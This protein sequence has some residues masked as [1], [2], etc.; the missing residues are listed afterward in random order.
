MKSIG[1]N[2]RVRLTASLIAAAF[3]VAACSNP[4][5]TEMQDRIARD[6]ETALAGPAPQLIAWSPDADATGVPTS[7]TITATFDVE[8]DEST[9][10]A[11]N[12]S[13]L[14]LPGE[15][16]VPGTLSYD[17]ASRTVS[18]TPSSRLDVETTYQLIVGTGVT[19]APGAQLAAELTAS[20]TTRFFHDDE[21]G[22][23]LTYTSSDLQ[24]DSSFPIYAEV[25]ALPW[26]Q[27][28]MEPTIT[29]ITSVQMIASG[30]Y[31]L[32]P[33]DLPAASE[34]L[35]LLFHDLNDDGTNDSGDTERLISLGADG[36]MED[37][38][39][40]DILER[41]SD[42]GDPLVDAD[43]NYII[44]EE[45]VVTPGAGY[46]LVYVDGSPVS[47]DAF[48]TADASGPAASRELSHGTTEIARNLHNL[49]DV[50][51]LRFTPATTDFYEITVGAT[52]FDLRVR[53]FNSDSEATIPTGAVASSTGQD[54]RVI[55]PGGTRLEG[56]SEYYLRVESPTSGLGEYEIAY[57]FAPI[58]PDGFEDTDDTKGGAIPLALGVGSPVSRTLEPYDH[59]W[60][61]IT[62]EEG[63]TYILSVEE[64]PSVLGW[65]L[66]ERGLDPGFRLEIAGSTSSTGIYD[67]LD[68][69]TLHIREWDGWTGADGTFYV[70]VSNNTPMIGDDKPGAAYTISLSYGPDGADTPD[71][72]NTDLT[73]E[74]AQFNEHA[75]DYQSS[76]YIPLGT[77]GR[78]RTIYTVEPGLSPEEDVDWLSF[79]VNDVYDDYLV[80]I[81][82]EGAQDAVITDFVLYPSKLDANDNIVPDTNTTTASSQWWA[83]DET[84]RAVEFYPL[85]RFGHPVPDPLSIMDRTWW[86]R[87]E[88]DSW[89]QANPLTGRYRV[90]VQAAP[91][92]L[93]NYY[94]DSSQPDGQV[95][96]RDANGDIFYTGGRDETPYLGVM[97]QQNPGTTLEADNRLDWSGS[98]GAYSIPMTYNSIFRKNYGNGR[99]E[100]DGV[101]DPASD[102]EFFWMQVPSGVASFWFDLYSATNLEVPLQAT[103]WEL[104]PTE[105]ENAR[106]DEVITEAEL[107]AAATPVTRAT[108]FDPAQ[109]DQES[110]AEEISVTSGENYFFLKIERDDSRTTYTDSDGVTHDYATTGQYWFR[111]RQ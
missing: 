35:V 67:E 29:T 78:V 9:L 102:Y 97:N 71:N 100:P 30:R 40:A 63:F 86:V 79:R 72:P 20:F 69:R 60:F 92:A 88:R 2:R 80:T 8:L 12:V 55:N 98:L 68:S 95:D 61:Q 25:I 19:S 27:A 42:T 73:D 24:L 64:D 89:A 5:V 4:L 33:A 11:A 51:Y 6:V 58:A 75:T 70:R 59:D 90:T 82:P 44:K 76:P 56:G 49:D 23:D 21:I 39:G 66:D 87:V 57:R 16:D 3:A 84:T 54:A 47:P 74:Y 83:S 52:T 81:R 31:R 107:T 103:L 104:T 43:G 41:D 15:T 1:L 96:M 18:F 77:E 110:L 37:P 99:G 105:F 94:I 62:L 32:S 34:Y 13:L 50:D 38:D 28:I 10:T 109:G 65:G 17:A 46:D 14:K 36:N 108:V 106:A 45:Y 48:E 7:T 91:D 85:N 53:L 111:F 101:N 22:L 93:D 26:P